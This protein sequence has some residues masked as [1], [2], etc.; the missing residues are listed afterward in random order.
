MRALLQGGDDV[1]ARASPGAPSPLEL[2][3][4]ATQTAAEGAGYGH[5]AAQLLVLAA[6]LW[7]PSTHALWSHAARARAFH[8]LRIGRLLA[9]SGRFVGLEQAMSDIW[10]VHVIPLAMMT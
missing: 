2:A 4:A 7:S 9:C 6:G 3:Q 1:H 5:D 8:L 10:L